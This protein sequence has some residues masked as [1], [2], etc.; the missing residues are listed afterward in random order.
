[1]Q[2]LPMDAESGTCCLFASIAVPRMLDVERMQ[3]QV[4]GRSKLLPASE[5]H[6]SLVLPHTRGSQLHPFHAVPHGLEL[7][8]SAQAAVLLC[9]VS[10]L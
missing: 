4:P 10:F 6:L 2:D 1:M 8:A 7:L 5:C 3:C 9:R